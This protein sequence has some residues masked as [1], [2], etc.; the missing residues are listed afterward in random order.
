MRRVVGVL[1]VIA[2]VAAA[3]AAAQDK[4]VSVNFGGGYTY[5]LSEIR[6]HLGDGWN[7]AAGVTFN[8]NSVFGIQVEY[9]FNGLGQKQIDLPV[10]AT[11]GTASTVLRP[12]YADMN[13][14]YGVFNAVIHTPSERA[15]RPYLVAGLGVYYRPIKV[16]TGSV[17]YVP[18]FCDPWWYGCYPGGFVPVDV[19]VGERI[20]TDFGVDFGGGVDVKL[21]RSM[22]FYVEA[23][24]HY[25]WG[26]PVTRQDGSTQKANGQFFPITFG[27]R[28]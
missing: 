4:P 20:S 3:P 8:M 5:A 1:F 22:A 25:I 24:Y 23:R 2:L 11:P 18:G 7:F 16:T 12:F 6:N 10:G 21:G 28:F 26:P 27:V 14:Q 13:M 9:G 15:L 19:I 17:G